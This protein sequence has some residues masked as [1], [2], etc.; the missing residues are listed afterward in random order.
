MLL[1]MGNPLKP[2]YG[3][4]LG[5][6]FSTLIKVLYKHLDLFKAETVFLLHKDY[7]AAIN[8]FDEIELQALEMADAISTA[9]IKQFQINV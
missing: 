7:Q 2:F 3:D 6:Q 5:E 1:I 8:T 4:Q 9:I